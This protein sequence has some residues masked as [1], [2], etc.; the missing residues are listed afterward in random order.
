MKKSKEILC[1][2]WDTI[3][4]NNL[5]ITTVPEG[6]RRKKGTESD[7][8]KKIM[9]EKCPNLGRDLN[10]QVHEARSPKT[11]NWKR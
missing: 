4:K 9:A 2:L 3:K 5:R 1:E 7:L 6:G 10:I 8:K 11:F